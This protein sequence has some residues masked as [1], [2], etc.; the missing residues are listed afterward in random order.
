MAKNNRDL[1]ITELE[2]FAPHLRPTLEQSI[3][4]MEFFGQITDNDAAK[5]PEPVF[6]EHIL[7]MLANRSGKQSLEKWQQIAGTV[8]RPIDVYD[9]KTNAHLFRV[10]PILRSI[11]EEF[12]GHGSRSAFEVVQT[13]E[14]KRRVMPAMGDAHIRVNLTD[15]VRHIPAEANQ[16]VHWNEILKRYGYPPI[17]K[18]ETSENEVE[19]AANKPNEPEID[20]F[21]DF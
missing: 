16:V 18:M 13:A 21:D 6:I 7:P 5:I 19:D 8:M 10:P 14:Q 4:G 3:E 2:D 11:N 17:L 20:G 9:A 1:G 15:R 12:T